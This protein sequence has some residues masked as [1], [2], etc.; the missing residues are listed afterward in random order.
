MVRL[1]FDCTILS[2]M[3]DTIETIRDGAESP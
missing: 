3:R 2:H 1:W